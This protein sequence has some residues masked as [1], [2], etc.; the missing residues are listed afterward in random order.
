[1]EAFLANPR[2]RRNGTI[3]A[4]DVP[5]DPLLRIM[6]NNNNEEYIRN[7]HCKKPGFVKYEG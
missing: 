1:L 5:F 4:C 6:R 7:W 3:V 2:A